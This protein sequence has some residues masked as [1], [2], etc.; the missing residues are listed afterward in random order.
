MVQFLSIIF[1]FLAFFNFVGFFKSS[2]FFVSLCINGNRCIAKFLSVVISIPI[3]NKSS[4]QT[5]KTKDFRVFSICFVK[6][7]RCDLKMEIWGDR[8]ET[9][10]TSK[11][12]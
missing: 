11:T 12:L 3:S 1:F 9:G 2:R 7:F 8:L 4:S 5:V 10:M 6:L